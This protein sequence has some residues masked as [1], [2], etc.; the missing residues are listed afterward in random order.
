MPVLGAAV[1][2]VLVLALDGGAVLAEVW[3]EAVELV[4]E[5]AK[6]GAQASAPA[7]KTAPNAIYRKIDVICWSV[8]RKDPMAACAIVVEFEAFYQK[9]RSR[10]L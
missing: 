1:V 5:S 3:G 9:I 4:V 6:P 2:V 10:G 7:L 8:R